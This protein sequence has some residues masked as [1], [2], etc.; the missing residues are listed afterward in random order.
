MTQAPEFKEAG[1]ITSLPLAIRKSIIEELVQQEENKCE[2]VKREVITSKNRGVR[3]IQ[4]PIATYH[5]RLYT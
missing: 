3:E 1:D 5:L 4:V 2:L